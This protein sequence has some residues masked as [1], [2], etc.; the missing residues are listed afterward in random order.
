[1]QEIIPTIQ[2]ILI[3][4]SIF[5]F[6]FASFRRLREDYPQQEVV[7]MSL[8][9]LITS[10][11]IYYLFSRFDLQLSF[12]P[13]LLGLVLIVFIFAQQNN[14]RFWAVMEILTVP[15]L[16]SWLLVSFGDW[17]QMGGALIVL[18]SNLYWQNYRRFSWYPSGKI[19]F[20]FLMDLV[21]FS[22]MRIGLD[23]W[24]NRLIELASWVVVFWL[25]VAGII[26]RAGRAT[27]T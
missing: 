26:F 17:F 2:T 21:I 6:L 4:I 25:S 8:L 15:G 20:L 27:E 24:Q 7:K 5:Y 23:F 11:A 19:G 16:V 13:F 22:V 3:P 9:N 18:V 1:M 12:I 14:W 10:G